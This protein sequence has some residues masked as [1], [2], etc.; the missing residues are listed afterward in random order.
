MKVEEKLIVQLKEVN[1]PHDSF[2]QDR[3]E[4]QFFSH[5]SLIWNII[6]PLIKDEFFRFKNLIFIGNIQK[7]HPFTKI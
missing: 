4:S 7:V 6:Y 2:Y 5:H 3:L 1:H